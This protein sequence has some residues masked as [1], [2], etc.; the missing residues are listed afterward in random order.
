MATEAQ[1]AAGSLE[2]LMDGESWCVSNFLEY[3]QLKDISPQTVIRQNKACEKCATRNKT[4]CYCSLAKELL[5]H[6]NEC[7]YWPP[8]AKEAEELYQVKCALS[9]YDIHKWSQHT[10]T[11]FPASKIKP[12]IRAMTVEEEELTPPEM[13][14]NA[15]LKYYEILHRLNLINPERSDLKTRRR[16]LLSYS[17]VS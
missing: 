7:K 11:T 6:H 15:W 13:L 1:T 14:T 5:A 12:M 3:R 16:N 9:E 2:S 4:I 17:W 10:D 8:V